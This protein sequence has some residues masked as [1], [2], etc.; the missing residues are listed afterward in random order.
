M[1]CICGSTRIMKI[2]AKC[3]DAAELQIPHLNLEI[4][5]GL[6]SIG[7][8]GGDYI[9]LDICMNCGTIQDWELISDVDV[10]EDECIQET[11][12]RQAARTAR[13]KS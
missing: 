10:L 11:L 4:E 9:N 5:G 1:I 13:T 3:S 7:P 2:S 8:F 12:E 6:P